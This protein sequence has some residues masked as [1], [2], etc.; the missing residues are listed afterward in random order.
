MTQSFGLWKD[1]QA[2]LFTPE[3]IADAE[4]W[5]RRETLRMELAELRKLAGKT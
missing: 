2:R 5:A 4:R 1:L 3:E